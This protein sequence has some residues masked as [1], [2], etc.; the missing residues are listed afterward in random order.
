MLRLTNAQYDNLQSLYFDIGGET[1]ELTPN[2][3][4]IP[5][6]VRVSA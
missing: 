3:Q 2:G 4:I 6:R 5:V 1:Y